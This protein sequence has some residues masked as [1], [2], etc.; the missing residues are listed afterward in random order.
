MKR[1]GR[2]NFSLAADVLLNPD[3]VGCILSGNV[4]Y[5][6]FVAM[7]QV[8]R[9]WFDVCTSCD[10]GTLKKVALHTGGLTRSVFT[11]L[12]AIS[13]SD[14]ARLPCTTH[15]SKLGRKYYLYRDQ[16]VDLVLDKGGGTEGWRARRARRA[17]QHAM[18]ADALGP[19]WREL[20]EWQGVAPLVLA[21]R[22]LCVV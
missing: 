13:W 16:A 15:V 8:C 19:H 21:N 3:L 11:G 10:A 4:D 12:F 6:T 14:A 17:Q 22:Q 18:H 5:K 20:L 7:S 9:V 1:Q 2:S